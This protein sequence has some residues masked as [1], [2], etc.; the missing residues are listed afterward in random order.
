MNNVQASNPCLR[1]QIDRAKGHLQDSCVGGLPIM[2]PKRWKDLND[3]FPRDIVRSALVEVIV[4]NQPEFPF[5]DISRPMMVSAFRGLQS[6]SLMRDYLISK[7]R[8]ASQGV[9]EKF[10]DYRYGFSTHGLGV[11][12]LGHSMNDVSNYF[13]QGLRYACGSWGHKSPIHKWKTGEKLEDL[14]SPLWR[15][16]NDRLTPGAYRAAIRLSAYVAT[17]FKPQCATVIYDMFGAKDV[18]DTSAGWG[19]RLAAFYAS[20]AQTYRAIDPNPETFLIYQQQCVEYERLLGTRVPILNLY[21]TIDGRTV[22]ECRGRKYVSIIQ[23]PAED[24]HQ[25][26]YGEQTHDVMFTS[27]PYYSTERYAEGTEAEGDQ[28]WKRYGDYTAWRDKFLFPMIEKSWKSLRDGGFLCVN[29]IDPEIRGRRYRVCDQ[30]VD[31]VAK[32]MDRAQFVGQLGMRIKQRP[33]NV[34]KDQ[35]DTHLSAMYIEPVW[36]FRKGG[37]GPVDIFTRSRPASL[38][39]LME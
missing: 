38:D 21:Q 10:T 16:N 28:S 36:V 30:M 32:E 24:V 13:Q 2:D 22:F 6:S 34:S 14:L 39:G 37:V 3:L 29:I 9:L 18:L 15:M 27:P 35:L 1:E 19:D 26:W 25:T 11:I 20:E 23:A 8:A 5:R 7:E 4:E 33:K 17:Q 12:Q 31:F